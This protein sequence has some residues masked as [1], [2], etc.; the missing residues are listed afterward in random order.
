MSRFKQGQ[1]FSQL[2]SMTADATQCYPR[3]I[4]TLPFSLRVPINHFYPRYIMVAPAG[5][6]S[7][8]RSSSTR[9]ASQTQRSSKPDNN[10]SNIGQAVEKTAKGA[11]LV[12]DGFD[13]ATGKSIPGLGV[14]TGLATLPGSVAAARQEARDGN[15]AGAIANG[16][17]AA[18]TA[19][20]VA[21]TGLETAADQVSKRA[22]REAFRQA[23]P[24]ASKAVV[25]A[26]AKEATQQAVKGATTQAA[27]H[28]V[29]DAATRAATNGSTVKAATGTASRAAAR[30]VLRQGSKG[31]AKASAKAAA[32]GVGKAAGRFVP[33]MNI[34]IAGL[35]TAQAAATLADPKASTG[36]KVTSVITAAGSIVGATNIPVVSQIGSGVSMVS[37]FIGSFF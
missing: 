33:G 5:S 16:T 37:D 34:A 27:K 9:A 4:N 22:A 36:K 10:N 14:A 21:S 19:L 13:K 20:N 28:A 29:L 35:D 31:A 3:A 17:N 6:S 25:N 11:A 2:G 23:A 15:T 26:A 1:F 8:A 18:A 7:S 12:N 32:K 30:N 24:N